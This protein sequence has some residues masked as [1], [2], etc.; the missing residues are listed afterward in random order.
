MTARGGI[1]DDGASRGL[2]GRL[3]EGERVLW[4]GAPA[5]WALAQHGFRLRLLAAYFVV[6]VGAAV[7]SVWSAGDA[8]LQGAIIVG[9]CLGLAAVAIGLVVLYARLV[10]RGTVYTVTNRRVVLRIG[11]AFPI[12][13]NVPFA[14]IESAAVHGYADGTGDI[15]LRLIP[16]QRFAYLILW[17]HAR[18]WRYGR[19]EPMLRAV[20][21]AARVA[22][23]LSRA[24]AAAAGTPA[25]LAPETA[26]VGAARGR[27][28]AAAA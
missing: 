4:Q 17:P 22:Q 24:L 20:P 23:V 1:D 10:A 11:V 21:D 26:T 8:P 3:P 18:P 14:S 12:M 6:I 9:R 27:A 2:P 25:P 5:T 28:S 13:L 19:S 16:P 15:A 7:A